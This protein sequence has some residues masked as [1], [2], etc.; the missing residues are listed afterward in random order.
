ML[1][2]SPPAR[3]AAPEARTTM[4]ILTVVVP[5]AAFAALWI[6]LS[7]KAIAW[8]F[9][10][11]A[12][13][14]LA[15]TVKGW[16]FVAVTSL[17]LYRLMRRLLGRGER[18]V[19]HAG[20]RAVIMPLLFLALAIM[21]LMA[22]GVAQVVVQEKAK[23]GARLR[24]IADLK[25]QQ[26]ESWLDERF[27]DAHLA[28][29][30]LSWT[31]LYGVWRDSGDAASF[32]QLQRRLDDFRRAFGYQA[33]F[34][35]D[36]DGAPLPGWEDDGAAID[37]VLRS[38]ARKVAPTNDVLSVGPY[39]DAGGLL[40]LDFV[41]ALPSAEGRAGPVIVL[42]SDPDAKLHAML[43]TWPTL[44]A[45]SE[46]FL[47]RRA[48]D[49]IEFLSRLRYRNG[50]AGVLRMPV[51]G[52]GLA[53][54]AARDAAK[55]GAVLE[56]RDYRHVP[57]F[58]VVREILGTD[59]FLVAKIDR[60][61]VYAEAA[62]DALWIV[63]AGVLALLATA[64]GVVALRQRDALAASLHIREI[65]A[66]KLSAL[67]L[68]ESIAAASAD[69]IVAKDLDGRY[70]FF[71]HEAARVV[72]KDRTAM[73]GQDDHAVFCPEDAARIAAVDRRVLAENRPI[74]YEETLPTASGP[75]TFLST[76]GPLRDVDGNTFG[77]FAVA[78]DITE[79]KRAERQLRDSES[80]LARAQAIAQ[81]GNWRLDLVTGEAICSD[82]TYRML[83]VPLGAPMNLQ[84]FVGRIH[85]QDL[86]RVL[87]AK[88]ASLRGSSYDMEHRIAVDGE[89]RW[90]RVK[91]GVTSFVDGRPVAAFGTMQDITER[92]KAE[93]ELRE[94]EARFRQLFDSAPIPMVIVGMDG[95][96]RGYNSHFVQTFGYTHEDVPTLDAW[97][98]LAYPD[99][100]YRR[101][102]V[103]TWNAALRAAGE[104]DSKIPPSEYRVTCKNGEVR[105]MVVSGTVFSDHFM[106]TAF[107]V[108]ERKAAEDQLRKLSL[109]IE[110]SPESVVITG[111]D[112]SI[113]YVNE[114]FCRVTGYSREEVIGNNPRVLSSGKTPR[115]TYEDMWESLLHGRSWKGQFHNRRKDGSDYVE[116]AHVAPIRQPDGRVTHYVAVKED[117]SEKKR[118]GAELDRYRFHLEDL[119]EA[120]TAALADARK[121]AE[122]ANR[123]KSTFLANMSHEIRTPMNAIV[124]L[125]HLLQRAGVAPEQSEWLRKIDTA[126][127][128]LLAIINDVLDLSKIEADRMVLEESDFEL[129]TL[130][131]NVGALIAEQA[132][133]K[134]LEVEVDVDPAPLWLSGDLTRLR[135]A[136]LN[137]AGNALK[138]TER[139]SV[140]LRARVAADDGEWLTLHFEVEDTGIGVAQEKIPH[141]FEAFEQGDA[142]T[143]RRYGGTGLGLAITRQLALLMGGAAG[144]TSEPGR[145]STFWFTARVRRGHDSRVAAPGEARDVETELREHHSGARLLLVEDNPINLE[146]ALE[147]LYGV[148]LTADT[149]RDGREAVAMAGAG[150]YDL[151]LMDIQ[152][153]ELDGLQATRAIRALP[154]RE[155]T[156]I[157]ALTANVFADDR[158]ACL[159]A[160]MNA[161]VAKPVEP[162][163]L[164][165]VLLEWLPDTAVAPLVEA[166]AAIAAD[167]ARRERL[168]RIPGLDG[169]RG[170]GAV[171]GNVAKYAQ[172]LLLFADGH[173]EDVA[174]LTACHRD[175]EIAELGRLAHAL[176]GAAGNLG[177]SRVFAAARALEAAA[178]QEASRDELE[179][180]TAELCESLSSLIEG[181]R[182]ALGEVPAMTVDVDRKR[183]AEVLASL[184]ALL[185][186]G[187]VAADDL[188]REEANLLRAALGIPAEAL[189]QRIAAY[190]FESALRAL[191]AAT[192]E[193]EV[194]AG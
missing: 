116:F 46:A 32:N 25:M 8:L 13:V 45:S 102:A 59:W 37:P 42:R 27:R 97:W 167:D 68:L 83:G 58:G 123:A 141:L 61:E 128:H 164:Y 134:G 153:P 18:A 22:V 132:R 6:L 179:R 162:R 124:G 157:L 118:I 19:S 120:R 115:E 101:W 38:A 86:Q 92:K 49:E 126:A 51:R 47:F 127:H 183:V 191:R 75:R 140:A 122:D 182:D 146:V 96:L 33:V 23:E 72:G 106:V 63:L 69:A 125:T 171:R 147:L 170:L 26:I 189:L 36:G 117:V 135:Q 4:A 177:A 187:D 14:A 11:P 64:A 15:S 110:Q 99:P 28:Q 67:Q 30:S 70:L 185:E 165:R 85:S 190:D 144:V 149:A 137:Y 29:S 156:P 54:Q 181:I 41:T 139:G 95:T 12:Q 105:T 50:A 74:T 78:R 81:V 94:S 9:G 17:L 71:N 143:T 119:V 93:A 180:W 192:P 151:I 150:A 34:L 176:R 112:A 174:R 91:G 175:G 73:L 168:L 1:Q 160:G 44:S 89:T 131:E 84:R 82:E 57:V 169:E 31:R 188:A 60:S 35:L 158:D 104:T 40:R 90:V 130:L 121:R 138:F 53:A 20:L 194:A 142:S 166:P 159:R 133:A 193:F 76:K 21:A 161:F 107:D 77:L 186:T 5:Y 136:L 172:L 87:A 62:S 154:G 145:G 39:R 184:G 173:A 129:Q 152:M 163:A 88:E 43:Q 108:T 16:L 65:L 7:D 178:R 79:R 52:P 148:G 103:E 10:D 3:F 48:G 80:S 98:P 113:E 114:A 24:A 109:A 111:T 55:S 100:A 66:E 2:E 155:S 56:G